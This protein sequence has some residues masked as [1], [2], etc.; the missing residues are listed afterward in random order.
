MALVGCSLVG[1]DASVSGWVS[2]CDVFLVAIPQPP[3]EPVCEADVAAELDGL[4]IT[5][6]VTSLRNPNR[7]VGGRGATGPVLVAVLMGLSPC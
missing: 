5:A 7:R 2:A 1:V 4:L 3:N 6:S